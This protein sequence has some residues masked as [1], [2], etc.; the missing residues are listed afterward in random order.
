MIAAKLMVSALGVS[1]IT[2][3]SAAGCLSNRN[4]TG[5]LCWRLVLDTLSIANVL[6]LRSILLTLAAVATGGAG[7]EP[8]RQ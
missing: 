3:G 2:A 1:G 4:L 8:E 5:Y 6:P 7:P